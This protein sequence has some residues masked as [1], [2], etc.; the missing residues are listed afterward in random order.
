MTKRILIAAIAALALTA[1]TT[2]TEGQYWARV[3]TG[4]AEVILTT[5]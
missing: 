5:R 2:T 4:V 3:A 1:C